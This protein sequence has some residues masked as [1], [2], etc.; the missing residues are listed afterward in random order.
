MSQQQNSS[1]QFMA[2][3]IVGGKPQ[4]GFCDGTAH[5]PYLGII[6]ISK[7]ALDNYI[8]KYRLCPDLQG[9]VQCQIHT[10]KYLG[11]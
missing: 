7:L 2:A 1:I 9:R 10:A 5:L 6:V 11:T 8:L 4:M 3:G